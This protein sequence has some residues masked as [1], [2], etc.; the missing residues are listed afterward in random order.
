MKNISLGK[1]KPGRRGKVV[2]I[3]GGTVLQSRLM[4][5]GIY[6]GKH[7]TKLG[8]FAL[9]GPVSVRSGRTVIALGHGMAK[10][11]IMETE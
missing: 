11:I 1:L 8:H 5:M 2:E 6:V 3:Q 4:T 9:N 10:K 7:I